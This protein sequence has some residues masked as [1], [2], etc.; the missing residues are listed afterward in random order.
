M[1]W[2]SMLISSESFWSIWPGREAPRKLCLFPPPWLD[3]ML[4]LFHPEQL[5]PHLSKGEAMLPRKT[6]DPLSLNH[7]RAGVADGHEALQNDV[8]TVVVLQHVQQRN[9]LGWQRDMM[10]V[11]PT[12]PVV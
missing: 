9:E 1:D 4:L 3:P 7:H 11:I 12:P 5:A 6:F 10:A 8:V 2:G